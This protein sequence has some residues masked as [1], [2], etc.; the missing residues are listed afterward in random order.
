MQFF[1]RAPLILQR[2]YWALCFD[3]KVVFLVY[4]IKAAKLSSKLFNRLLA[5]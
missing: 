1:L 5:H 3:S 2:C 4:Q